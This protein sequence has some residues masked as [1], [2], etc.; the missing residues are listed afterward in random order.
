MGAHEK[1]PNT[2]TINIGIKSR[3]DFRN[4]AVSHAMDAFHARRK[5]HKRIQRNPRKRK[6]LL[7][8]WGL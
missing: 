6:G 8:W 2:R 7:P 3:M 1:I 4:L 5:I